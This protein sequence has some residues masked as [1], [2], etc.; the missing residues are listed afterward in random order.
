MAVLR[1]K[2]WEKL[3]I[4]HESAFLHFNFYKFPF[5]HFKNAWLGVG[6]DSRP[7]LALKE[8]SHLHGPFGR[9]DDFPFCQKAAF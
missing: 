7:P 1:W 9:N 2:V 5:K 3:A 4:A 6:R 8:R